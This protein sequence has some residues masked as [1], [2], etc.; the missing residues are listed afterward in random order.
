MPRLQLIAT[1]PMGLEAVVAREL[2][3]LGYTDMEVENGRVTFTGDLIDICRRNLWLR[4]SDRILVKMGEFNA[5]T[6]DELFEGTKA[7]P[8]EDWIP[9]DGQF[10][11]EGRSH[12]S[13]LSG[14]PA[15]Q[16]IV[17]SNR[18]EAEAL[19]PYGMVPEDGPR[20]VVEVSS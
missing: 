14:V 7:L 12:K 10:P 11:V 2:K 3:E 4:T 16:G 19:A 9:A 17:K 1:A 6:F 18:G 20:Y 13:R 8:W 5:F 15:C